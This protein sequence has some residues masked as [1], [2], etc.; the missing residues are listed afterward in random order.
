MITRQK[1]EWIG[2]TLRK[3]NNITR[4]A[5]SSIAGKRK[6]GRPR[7]TLRRMIEHELG[8]LGTTWN[9]TRSV[10]GDRTKWRD[11]VERLCEK[12]KAQE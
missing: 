4:K 10:A 5:L 11:M 9:E 8:Q 6:I 3:P 1:W 12:L 2:H 7:N